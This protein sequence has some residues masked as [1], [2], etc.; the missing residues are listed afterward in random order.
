MFYYKLHKTDFGTMIAICDKELLGKTLKN[1]DLD[2]F[3]NPR[4]YG[5]E[6]I[7]EKVLELIVDVNDGN[8]VGNKIVG[9]LLKNKI[10]ANDSIIKIGKIK[11]AQFTIL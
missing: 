5:E 11:H 4:F 3:V 2:F 9:L 1:K 10:I 8:V 6:E 7:N